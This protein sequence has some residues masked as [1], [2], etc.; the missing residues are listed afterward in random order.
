MRLCSVKDT[1]EGT[2]RYE[3]EVVR[4]GKE[5]DILV[6]IKGKYLGTEGEDEAEDHENDDEDEDAEPNSVTH[7]S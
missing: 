7:I 6:S 2:V 4:D 5:F 1:V 3:A